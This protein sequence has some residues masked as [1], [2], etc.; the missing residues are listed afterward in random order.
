VLIIVPP[1][2][3]KRPPAAS[4]RPVALEE[5][6]FPALL[7]TRRQIAEAL[8]E[9][10]AHQDAL[11]RLQV[12]PTHAP[13]VAR[14]IRLFELPAMPVLDVYTGPLHE[15]LDASRLSAA[16]AARAEHGLVVA[17]ALWGTLR[18]A[19]RIPPYR[20]HV[21][22]RLIGIDRLKSTW[23]E[24]L[25][26]VLAEVAGADGVV[27]DLRSPNYQA[28]GMP[29]GLGHRTVTLRVEQGPR[30]HRI[31]DVI[32]K[33]VRGEAARHLLESGADPADAHAL[34]DVLADRWPVRLDTPARPG[35]PWT[36]M[37]SIDE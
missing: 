20:L 22:A 24:V 15:G 2:E 29:T 10:S 19:D 7:P 23:R 34:A 13:E 28:A 12:G 11:D 14:N 37:L 35:K 36:M 25:P 17:S 26:D 32:A 1:S 33:R 4:G 8:V 31:G 27:V 16:A 9:T 18:P 3:S 21:C 30:G 5:L 6:S